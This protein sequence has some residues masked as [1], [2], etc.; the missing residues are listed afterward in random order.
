MVQQGQTG[1]RVRTVQYLLNARGSSL[2]VDGSFGPATDTAVRSFQSSH[3]LTVDG[4]VGTATWQALVTTV[5]QGSSGPAVSAVQS[6]LN[7][8][9]SSLT[10]D[11]SFGP[12]TDTAVRSFQSS[13]GLTVDGVVGTATWQAL[14]A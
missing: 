4:V 1:E 13:H 6:Q 10:V 3:G 5:Q 9:G 8:H 2:T 12:A 14:V 7:A 11:G